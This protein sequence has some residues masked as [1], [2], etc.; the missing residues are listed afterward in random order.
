MRAYFVGP[1]EISGGPQW[2]DSDRF[3]IDAKAE[4]PVDDDEVLM[5]M[6]R[7]LLAERFN[8][9]IHR[10]TKSIETYVLEAAKGGPK[11]EKADSSTSSTTNSSRGRIDARATTMKHF[12]EGLSRQMD[13]PVIDETGL[14][15]AYNLKLTW[16]REIDQVVNP[17]QISTM[18]SGQSVFTALQ[19]LGLRL[20]A[21]KYIVNVML[22]DHV[23]LPSEN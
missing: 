1:K 18:D 23:E 9:A 6:L 13:F 14:D 16:T 15:G 7:T 5:A 4:Q 11:L 12:A 20:R 10:E 21:R 19:Q 22:V 17:G 2:I 8:L 3:D